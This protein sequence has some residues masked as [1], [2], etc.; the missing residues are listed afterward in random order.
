MIEFLGLIGLCQE[1]PLEPG[2]I[3]IESER[4]IIKNSKIISAINKFIGF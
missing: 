1:N 2:N 3:V 4:E